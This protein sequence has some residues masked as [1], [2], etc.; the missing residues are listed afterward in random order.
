M[1]KLPR[2]PEDVLKDYTRA[3]RLSKRSVEEVPLPGRPAIEMQIRQSKENLPKLRM[4]YLKVI[5]KSSYGFFLE[6]ED[7]AKKQKFVDIALENGVLLVD[8][9]AVFQ[10]LADQVQYSI[11]PSREF[12]VT[13][14]GLLDHALRELV[15]ATG[16]DGV[17]NRTTIS[18]LRIVKNREKLVDYIRE[19]VANSNG[20]VP[21][22]VAAQSE[23]IRQA[24]DREFAGKRLVVAVKRA[25]AFNRVALAGL[26]TKNTTVN[27]DEAEEVNEAYVEE[28]I[29]A[30]LG[31]KAKTAPAPVPP[32]EA[33]QV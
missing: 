23:I 13:Q 25:D 30:G 3:N 20:A 1:S 11:G 19:L 27:V 22:V 12:S 4:E 32:P 24:I 10:K 28:V 14:V 2:T 8:A 16:H 6:G 9:D 21:V 29:R 31:L 5:L 18:Q 33:P 26:F 17:L 7:D 15:E